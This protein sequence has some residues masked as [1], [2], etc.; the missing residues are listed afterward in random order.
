MYMRKLHV[1]FWHAVE[2]GV[3]ESILGGHTPLRVQMHHLLCIEKELELFMTM[4]KIINVQLLKRFGCYK[5]DRV[6]KISNG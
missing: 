4:D 2:V 5:N 1:T 6:S 3:G